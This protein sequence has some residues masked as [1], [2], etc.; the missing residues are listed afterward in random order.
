MSK[1]NNEEEDEQYRKSIDRI[2]H[3]SVILP[4][5]FYIKIILVVNWIE[6]SNRIQFTV[7]LQS[8]K[9]APGI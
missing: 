2:K 1:S 8:I 5:F 4:C 9:H 3:V 6:R 7:E